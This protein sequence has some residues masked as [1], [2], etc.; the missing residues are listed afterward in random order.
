MNDCHRSRVASPTGKVFGGVAVR[1]PSRPF[2][3][4]RTAYAA[5]SGLSRAPATLTSP[6]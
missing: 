1:F 3:G 5:E 6:L 2:I 4:T